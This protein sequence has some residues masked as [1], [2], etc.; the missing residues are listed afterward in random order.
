M[1]NERFIWDDDK[2]DL[3]F[4]KHGIKFEEA[5]TVFEDENALYTDDDEHSLH[6]YRFKVLGYSK[7]ARLL[8]VCHCYR[9]GDSFI[10]LISARKAN[11]KEQFQYHRR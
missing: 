5:S 3:N 10:R 1:N 8:L 9:N 2:Y 7:N 11:K 6:E 4:S